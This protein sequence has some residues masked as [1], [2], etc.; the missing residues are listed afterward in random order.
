M[1]L[2]AERWCLGFA[3]ESKQQLFELID[4]FG[5]EYGFGGCKNFR[6]VIDFWS[7]CSGDDIVLLSTV[8]ADRYKKMYGTDDEDKFA[9]RDDD[10]IVSIRT[11]KRE[12]QLSKLK[13]LEGAE[14]GGTTEHKKPVIPWTKMVT[15]QKYLISLMRKFGVGESVIEQAVKEARKKYD[16]LPPIPDEKDIYRITRHGTKEEFHQLMK[17]IREFNKRAVNVSMHM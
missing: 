7:C 11:K 15:K 17:Q 13:F 5:N 9:P 8:V 10:K 3:K 12:E 1:L 14:E 16:K 4:L 2:R 6:E